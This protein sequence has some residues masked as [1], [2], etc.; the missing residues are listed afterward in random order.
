MILVNSIKDLTSI[1]N[2]VYNIDEKYNKKN[3]LLKENGD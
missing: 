2:K 3:I 1:S